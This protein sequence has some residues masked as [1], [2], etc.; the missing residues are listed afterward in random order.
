MLWVWVPARLLHSDQAP[1]F[2]WILLKVLRALKWSKKTF[3]KTHYFAF[4]IHQ[5]FRA[6]S[7][8]TRIVLRW[9]GIFNAQCMNLLIIRQ[10]VISN[11]L[12]FIW[13]LYLIMVLTT[14]AYNLCSLPSLL[15]KPRNVLYCLSFFADSFTFWLKLMCVFN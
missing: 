1:F 2:T 4:R 12:T 14:I 15:A 8:K 13:R 5:K 3:F 6:K 11:V 10:W 9:K 7:V